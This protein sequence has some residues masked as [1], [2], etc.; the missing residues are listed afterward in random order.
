[1]NKEELQMVRTKEQIVAE[2]IELEIRLSLTK[3]ANHQLPIL[4]KIQKLRDML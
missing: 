2:I 1:V 4:R 3:V